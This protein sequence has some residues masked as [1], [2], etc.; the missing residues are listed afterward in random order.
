MYCPSEIHDTTGAVLDLDTLKDQWKKIHQQTGKRN[1]QYHIHFGGGEPTVNKNFL[2]FLK[3]LRENYGSHIKLIGFCTN[4]SA[5]TRYYLDA[6]EQVDQIGFSTHTEFMSVDKFIH[7]ILKVYAKS[8]KLNKAVHVHVMNE[9][10]ATLE[11]EYIIKTLSK[12][13][14]PYSLDEIDYS[15]P[16]RTKPLNLNYA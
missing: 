2:P 13:Q 11:I 15:Q 14:V 1:R 12:Y 9:Y 8:L 6:L 3:W 16:I 4:G 10:W 5:S 7:T